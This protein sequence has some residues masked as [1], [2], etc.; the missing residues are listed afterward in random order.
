MK[1]RKKARNSSPGSGNIR[2]N[3]NNLLRGKK[4]YHD[5]ERK[6]IEQTSHLT[7]SKKKRGT[8]THTRVHKD[9]DGSGGKKKL[10]FENVQ[11]M[12]TASFI[13]KNGVVWETSQRPKG[14]TASFGRFIHTFWGKNRVTF[15]KSKDWL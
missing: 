7:T 1:H 8:A 13:P 14:K 9:V 6:K 11:G 15:I 4:L 12:Q 3:Q 10:G 2:S 5:G